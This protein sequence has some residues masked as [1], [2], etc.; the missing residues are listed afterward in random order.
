MI[1]IGILCILNFMFLN[2]YSNFDLNNTEKV[3]IVATNIIL[4]ILSLMI[5]EIGHLIGSSVT[6]IRI[7][8]VILGSFGGLLILDCDDL[9]PYKNKAVLFLSGPISSTL[10]GISMIL[11]WHYYSGFEFLTFPIKETLENSLALIGVYNLL[12]GLVNIFPALPFDSGILIQYYY[13]R[14]KIIQN[15]QFNTFFKFWNF[16]FYLFIGSLIVFLTISNVQYTL[17]VLLIYLILLYQ[18]TKYIHSI[19]NSSTIR[20]I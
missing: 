13:K 17:L 7:K 10:V 11:M 12:I 2:S 3:I 16:G 18:E 20:G 6:R 8:H 4:M 15:S 14:S 1:N 5:H 9:T 19:N